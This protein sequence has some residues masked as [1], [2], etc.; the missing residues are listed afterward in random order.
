MKIKSKSILQEGDLVKFKDSGEG[1]VWR[2]WDGMAR[3]I[4]S[5][6][7][8]GV[9]Y[10]VVA[11]SATYRNGIKGNVTDLPNICLSTPGGETGWTWDEFLTKEEK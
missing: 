6:C 9:S 8:G 5:I 10:T 1:H 4:V 2:L 7:H 3:R 11:T